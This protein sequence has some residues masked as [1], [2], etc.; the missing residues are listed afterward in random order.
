MKNL[1]NLTIASTLCISACIAAPTLTSAMMRPNSPKP[2]SNFQTK[3]AYIGFTN[4]GKGKLGSRIQ[5]RIL[6]L[7]GQNTPT[8]TSSK[9]KLPKNNVSKIVNRFETKISNSSNSSSK[10]KLNTQPKISNSNVS[11]LK[12]IFEN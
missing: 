8:T 11:Q 9:P 10:N 5:T 4:T 12:K 2:S 3:S 7:E 6:M 1:K